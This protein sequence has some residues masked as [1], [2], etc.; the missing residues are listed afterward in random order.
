MSIT[1]N[2]SC[3]LTAGCALTGSCALS[4]SCALTGS[5]ALSGS[6]ALTGGCALSG[7]CALTGGCALSI[8]IHNLYL[9]RN[10]KYQRNLFW[11]MRTMTANKHELQ[12]NNLRE[13]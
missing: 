11:Y 7:S 10:K 3:A 1:I 6:C 13:L 12:K 5:C 4:G 9:S 8:C 2:C